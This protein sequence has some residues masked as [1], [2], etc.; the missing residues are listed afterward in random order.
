ML[1]WPDTLDWQRRL[2]RTGSKKSVRV[3]SILSRAHNVVSLL[4]VLR[5]VLLLVNERRL[6]FSSV[7]SSGHY[8]LGHRTEHCSRIRLLREFKVEY[9]HVAVVVDKHATFLVQVREQFV[10]LLKRYRVLLQCTEILE[11]ILVAEYKHFLCLQVL[12]G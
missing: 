9:V 7:R 6:V 8:T 12:V 10:V 1:E 4:L 11:E 2:T 3:V 5:N